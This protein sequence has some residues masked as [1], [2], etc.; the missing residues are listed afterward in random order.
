MLCAPEKATKQNKSLHQRKIV[1]KFTFTKT[2][3]D[4]ASV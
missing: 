3:T 1:T 2:A 4:A